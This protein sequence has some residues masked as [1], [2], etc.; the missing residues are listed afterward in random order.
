MSFNYIPYNYYELNLLDKKIVEIRELFNEKTINT[1]KQEDNERD[2]YKIY[3][4]RNK[5]FFLY[6]GTTKQPLLSRIKSGLLADGKNGY[7]GYKWK[8]EETVELFV[9]NFKGL[10]KEEIES[11]EAE[12]VSNIRV[13]YGKWPLF[14][15]EIH[16][17]N[18]F[19]FGIVIGR[20]IIKSLEYNHPQ[21][22]KVKSESITNEIFKKPTQYGLRGDPYLWKELE[23]L[24]ISKEIKN[25]EGFRHFLIQNIERII[26]NKLEKGK[27]IFVAK[28][29]F[30]GM[31][32]GSISCDFW[33]D[34]G[35]PIL[36]SQ[37]KEK[38][39]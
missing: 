20:D 3:I 2:S 21:F 10:V 15:N 7:H 34:K 25:E 29:N 13:E 6:I 23:I 12:L 32:G 4:V 37:F 35:I 31:S 18:N 17:N 14:Q 39:R 33:L 19:D 24:S 22:T 5:S 38:N 28:Y 27:S 30:G 8:N 11:I 9:Y 26:S 16:F 1:L 36:M